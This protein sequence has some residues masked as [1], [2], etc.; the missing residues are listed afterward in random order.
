MRFPTDIQALT[1]L[2]TDSFGVFYILMLFK[3]TVLLCLLL[4][5]LCFVLLN[6]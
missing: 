5:L 2:Y 4:F 6:K 3:I 1:A